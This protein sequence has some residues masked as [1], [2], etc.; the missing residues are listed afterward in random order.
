MRSRLGTKARLRFLNR[1]ARYDGDI[2]FVDVIY[3][4]VKKGDLAPTGAEALFAH[5]EPNR[6]PRL[7]AQKVTDDNRNHVA[8]HLRKSVWSSYIKD[9]YEDFSEYLV[10]IVRASRD[11][12]TPDRIIGTHKLTVDVRDLLECGSWDGVLELVTDSVFDRLDGMSNTRRIV[13]SL[14]DLLG[15][16]LDGELASAA[17]PYVELRHLLVHADGVAS[18]DFCDAFPEFGAYAGEAIKLTPGTIHDAR[19]AITALVEHIDERV[20]A[21]GLIVDEHM[22]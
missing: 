10:E 11:G 15:L 17:Q 18:T 22:Q 1:A 20:V 8:A 6:H 16:E 7:S 9:L 4:A 19:T 21:S 13:Q 5:V 14:S 3:S 2:E 12:F